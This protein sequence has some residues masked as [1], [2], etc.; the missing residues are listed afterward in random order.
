MAKKYIFE[1]GVMKLNPE[2]AKEQAKQDNPTTVAQPTQAL[3]IVSSMDDVQAATQLQLKERGVA[4]TLSDA[5]VSSM[6]I[7]Q[8]D[9]FVE[10]YKSKKPLDGGEVLEGLT[11]VFSRYEVPIGLVNKLLALSEY[12]LNFIIDNS[13][14]MGSPTD[15]LVGDASEPMKS[16]LLASGRKAAEKM[17]RWE[18]AEDRLHVLIE[19]L[20]YIP[21]QSLTISCF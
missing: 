5:T 13:A 16:R 19:F 3:A 20:Q 18:E 21:A 12:H 11:G 4:M 17:T 6:Q 7:M 14:S 8:D 9:E 10:S 2:Y 1:N 15:A